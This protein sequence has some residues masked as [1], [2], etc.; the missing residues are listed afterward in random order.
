MRPK[1]LL[2]VGVLVSTACSSSGGGSGI[3][4]GNISR[5][6]L[7]KAWPLT[8]DSGRLACHGNTVRFTNRKRYAVHGNAVTFIANGTTYAVNGFAVRQHRW[9]NIRPIWADAGGGLKKDLG[10]LTERGL[11]LC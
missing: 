6:D 9:S 4:A 1:T 8:V 3:R 11:R 10:P 5:S 7:G 2:V